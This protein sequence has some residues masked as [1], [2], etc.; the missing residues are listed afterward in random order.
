MSVATTCPTKTDPASPSGVPD[1]VGGWVAVDLASVQENWR[2]VERLVGPG[3]IAAA[4]VKADAYGLGMAPVAKALAGSGCRW[5]FVASADEGLSLAP[6]LAGDFPSARIAVL[7][8]PAEPM[9]AFP[10]LVPVINDLSQLAAW[11]GAA[12]GRQAILHLDTGMSR[13]GM[14]PA[15]AAKLAARP[16]LLDGIDLA[17]VM[18]HLACS[19]DR[20]NPMNERQRAEFVRLARLFPGIPRSLASSHG[21]FL[22][23]P[24]QFDMVRIGAAL[25]GLNPL[26]GDANPM[27]PVVGL[28]ARILQLREIG[29]GETV[30]YG[31]TWTARRPGRIATLG[32][33][34]ADGILRAAGNNA[35]CR[36]GPAE[37]PMI[38]RISMD[39]LS[40]DVS[41]VPSQFVHPGAVV[42]LVGPHYTVD[43]L[44]RD[45]GTIGYEVLTRLGPRLPRIYSGTY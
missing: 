7:S 20:D 15:E 12:P 3:C 24:Y 14:P 40:I 5:F 41:D 17:F 32:L 6:V 8:G 43:E 31:A 37:A 39:L 19:D 16:A 34:Y 33:G 10:S 35:R 38:G 26:P 21:C 44:A 2:S 11:R 25:Y 30:G 1:T 36:V 4:V 27:R 45:S 23:R 13:L 29:A 9:A 22:G 28:R 42:D 18:S